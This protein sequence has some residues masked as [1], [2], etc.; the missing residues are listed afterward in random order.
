M[1]NSEQGNKW[2]LIIKPERKFFELNFISLFKY[3]DLIFMFVKRD[4]VTFYKQS[5]LGRLWYIIHPLFMTVVFTFIFRGIANI[6]TDGGPPFI[7]YLSGTV[8][9][10]Y[11]AICITTTSNTF[12]TNA[13]IFSKVYF[14]KLYL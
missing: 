9:W 3:K 10:G 4:F 8:V 13:G 14:D 11:F 12:V 5:I 2:D 7:F 6:P 1:T